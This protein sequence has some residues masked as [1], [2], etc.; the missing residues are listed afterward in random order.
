ARRGRAL[1][2]PRG[3]ARRICVRRRAG[4]SRAATGPG[5][6]RGRR[7]VGQFRRLTRRPVARFAADV[8]RRP[9]LALAP[10]AWRHAMKQLPLPGH[11]SRVVASRV[12]VLAPHADD[13][14]VGCG[15]LLA[16]L[17]ADGA[18]ATVFYLTDS[19]GGT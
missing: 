14:I 19:S 3:R 5:G 10:L 8:A 9:A 2:L 12:L 13:E 15:G 6:A 7:G 1:A 16:Q 4:R 17:L 18:A 11:A